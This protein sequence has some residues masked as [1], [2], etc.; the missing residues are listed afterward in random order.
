MASDRKIAI[1]PARGGSKRIPR[2]NIR[3]FCGKPIV[4]YSIEAA[5]ASEVFDEVMV[6]TDDLEISEIAKKYGAKVPFMR[7]AEMS[8]DMA[9]TAPVLEEVLNEYKKR[10]NMFSHCACIYP[11]APFVTSDRLKE[12][13]ATLISS[14]ADEVLPIVKFSYP[15]QR[16]LVIRDECVTMLYPDNFNKRSQ[17]LEPIYHDAGQFYLYKT[18][19]ILSMD[20]G[21]DKRIVPLVLPEN[22]AQDIDTEEDW[23]IAEMKYQICVGGNIE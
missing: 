15:P 17:D 23:Q 3:N 5:I 14:N 12:G 16:C 9:M 13:M 7:S 21:F 22:E 20:K 18:S 1:I 6:S 8:T 19:V 4:A 11:C 2:K 10:G